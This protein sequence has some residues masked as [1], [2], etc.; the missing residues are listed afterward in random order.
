VFGMWQAAAVGEKKVI[1]FSRSR[2]FLISPCQV[3]VEEGL[4]DPAHSIPGKP[5]TMSSTPHLNEVVVRRPTQAVEH[6]LQRRTASVP[7]I[8]Q[9]LPS[10]IST[11]A[12]GA[13]KRVGDK[14]RK[15]TQLQNVKKSL[16]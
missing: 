1:E 16:W 2:F 8:D 14:V 4:A 10:I 9:E 13:D 7:W 6:L 5:L 15:N 12:V 3:A 11:R